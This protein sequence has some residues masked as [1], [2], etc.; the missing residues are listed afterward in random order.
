MRRYNS[1]KRQEIIII[2]PM[3]VGKTT[4][5]LHLSERLEILNFPIDRLKWYYRFKNEYDIAIGTKILKSE[6]FRSLLNY[7]NNYFNLNE[8]VQILDEFRGGIFD[9]GASHTYFENKR[10][11]EEAKRIF[12]PFINVILLLPTPNFSTNCFILENRLRKRYEDVEWKKEVL[13]SYLEQNRIFLHSKSY[14]ELAKF[15]F[16][17]ETKSIED[18]GKEILE[19]VSL[20]Q[21]SY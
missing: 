11:L 14:A 7:G 20:F 10:E 4:L 13:N 6:G 17:T 9:F 8:I 12:D 19:K 1:E 2:G 16:Y 21:N 15:T 3:A 18:I 5:A